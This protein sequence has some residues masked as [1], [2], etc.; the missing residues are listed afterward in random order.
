MCGL[1]VHLSTKCMVN[2]IPEKAPKENMCPIP[3]KDLTDLQDGSPCSQGVNS[4]VDL[5]DVTN[6]F[7]RQRCYVNKLL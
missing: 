4:D 1:P 2:I 3:K 7:H 5:D 6:A